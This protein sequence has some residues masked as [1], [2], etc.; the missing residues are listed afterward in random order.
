MTQKYKYNNISIYQ[1]KN[2]T[3][4]NKILYNDVNKII[5]KEG[6]Q[7]ITVH[8]SFE[9]NFKKF[10]DSKHGKSDPKIKDYSQVWEELI[11]D[12]KKPL[13]PKSV[14]PKDD[15]YTYVNYEWL[16]KMK[17]NKEKYYYTRIDSFRITQEKVY[18][19]LIDIVKDY[20]SKHSDHK[21]KMIHNFYK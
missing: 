7:C 15:F 11:R 13:A 2:K 1:M 3:R 12:F 9:E 21:S 10:L 18:Y 16:K 5:I 14:N 19:Q 4:K 17:S 8:K 20:T 6:Q